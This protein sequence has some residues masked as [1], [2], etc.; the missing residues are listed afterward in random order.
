MYTRGVKMPLV[1]ESSWQ[2]L[3]RLKP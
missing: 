2:Q 3:T 1:V